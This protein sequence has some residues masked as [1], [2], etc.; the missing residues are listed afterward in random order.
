MNVVTVMHL[1][2]LIRK[3]TCAVARVGGI[4]FKSPIIILKALIPGEHSYSHYTP[5][6]FL[7]LCDNCV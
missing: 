7:Y 2:L 6:V 1:K 3:G 5:H 4:S